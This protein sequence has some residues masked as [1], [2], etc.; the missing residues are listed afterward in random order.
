MELP[1][2]LWPAYVTDPATPPT[3]EQVDSL[4]IAHWGFLFTLLVVSRGYTKYPVAS[5]QPL[6]QSGMAWQK[7]L[8]YGALWHLL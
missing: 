1:P 7:L 2:S 5:F 8:C 6:L 4:S 3:R